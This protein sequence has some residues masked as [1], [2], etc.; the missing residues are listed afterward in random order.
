MPTCVAEEPKEE[1]K[2]EKKAPPKRPPSTPKKDKKSK[3]EIEYTYESAWEAVVNGTPDAEDDDAR[4]TA[5]YD[6]LTQVA[7]G[8]KEDELTSKEWAAV[9]KYTIK[10]MSTH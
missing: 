4:A 1:P 7:P 6:M 5:W 9:V 3:V 2:E 10:E 8:K